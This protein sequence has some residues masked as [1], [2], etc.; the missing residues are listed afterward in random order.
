MEEE[1]QKKIEK[2]SDWDF[3]PYLAIGAIVFIVFCC[4]LAC[5]VTSIKCVWLML[6]VIYC[7]TKKQNVN[8]RMCFLFF[9]KK[10]C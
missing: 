10:W 3:R 1:K 6:V 7:S 9:C 5:F 4:C 2:R 8:I